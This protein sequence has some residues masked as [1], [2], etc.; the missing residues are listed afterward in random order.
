[1]KPVEMLS[2]LILNSSKQREIVFDG[3]LGS[4]STLMACENNWRA[5]RGIELEA[6]YCDVDVKR[7]LKY[8]QEN[9]LDHEV[10]KN[11][12]KLTP[13]EIEEYIN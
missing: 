10:V 8:M 7:W 6:G 11:G 2:Y 5:C 9:N 12:E 3:F 4:G 1:M 13:E